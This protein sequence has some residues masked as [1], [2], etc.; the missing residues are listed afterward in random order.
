MST[1]SA[2][3][4]AAEESLGLSQAERVIDTFVAPRKTFLDI[5]R[6]TSWWV[7]YVLG[8]VFAYVFVFAVQQK[9][10]WDRLV[11]N[12]IS[13]SPI[14]QQQL[15]KAPPEQRDRIVAMRVAGTKY[16]FYALPVMSILSA[17]VITGVLLSTFNFGFGARFDFSTMMAIVMYSYL[18]FII[19]WVL[20]AITIFAG[21]D[22]DAFNAQN[23]I[24]TNPAYVMDPT[25][26]K[27]LYSA[28]SSL[29]LIAFWIIFLLATGV[30]LNSKVKRGPAFI[31]VFVWYLVW[32]LG[33]G[34]LGA[35]LG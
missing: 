3:P 35:A 22:P 24:A 5:R 33:T 1:P 17:L 16:T 25:K 4:P 6:N 28:V 32:K 15:E 2:V 34:A 8:A 31:A 19:Q 11:E 12:Q 14:A 18:P 7:P 29:D 9:I 13:M 10:G 23:P 21:S 26:H 27:F 30:A 20:T